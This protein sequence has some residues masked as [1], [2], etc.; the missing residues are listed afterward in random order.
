MIDIEVGLVY[1]YKNIEQNTR[2][3]NPCIIVLNVGGT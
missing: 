3:G 1:L 2:Y